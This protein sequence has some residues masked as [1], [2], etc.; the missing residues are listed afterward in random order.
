MAPIIFISRQFTPFIEA[1]LRSALRAGIDAYVMCDE[2]PSKTSKRILHYSDD[3]MD[4]IGWT[5]HM[6]QERNRITAW[7]KA[8]YHAYTMKV[9]HVWICEDDVYWNRPSVLKSIVDTEVTDDLIASERIAETYWDQ[10]SWYHWNKVELLTPKKK[11]WGASFNQLCR[12]SQRL[13]ERMAELAEQRARLYFHEGMF[14]TLCKVYG[15]PHTYIRDLG[16]PMYI[17]I[18]WDKPFTSEKI[19]EILKQQHAVLLHPVK[20]PDVAEKLKSWRRVNQ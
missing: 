20:D 8:T 17:E 19:G 6:S 4:S 7:D 13:L 18:R 1:K 16:L 2:Q 11:Y 10:P 3:E 5:H 15:Y 12:L 9:P 14:L